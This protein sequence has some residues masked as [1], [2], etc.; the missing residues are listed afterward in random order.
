MVVYLTLQ[1]RS[2]SMP[3]HRRLTT[4]LPLV[5]VSVASA[6]DISS[7]QFHGFAS[8]GYLRT[9]GDLYEDGGQFGRDTNRGSFEFNEFGLNAI[10]TPAD[11]LRIGI[12]L[13]AYDLGKYGNDQ[14]QLDWAF[15]EYQV[16]VAWDDLSLS[17]V[18]GRFKTGHAFY[19]DYRD[20]DMTRTAVFLPRSTYSATF[21]DFFLAANGAQI[22]GSLGLHAAGSLD[23]SAFTGTQNLNESQGP[24]RDIFASAVNQDVALPGLGNLSLRLDKFD[25]LV[26]QRMNGGNLTWNTPVDGLRFKGSSLYAD[27]FKARGS[28]TATLPQ[29]AFLG[30]ASGTSTK[31]DVEIDVRHWFDIT[32]GAEYQVGDLTLAS[33]V[34]WQYYYASSQIGAL[35]F[36]PFGTADPYDSGPNAVDIANRT[37]GG[38]LSATYQLAFLPGAWSHLSVYGAGTLERNTNPLQDSNS[39]TRSGALAL[40]YDVADHFLVKGQFDRVQETDTTG[41]ATYGSQFSLK[42]TFDF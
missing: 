19:N 6:A 20:L 7:V 21:R 9:A 27:S 15:G 10:A 26:L 4:L 14:V 8:Q 35:D 17:V 11:R 41:D 40:R 38:Y 33:E 42:T 22:N 32:T 3:L 12:Q 24:M 2:L 25:S 18:A 23:F 39:Y 36:A 30:G 13:N 29:S 5:A 31:T 37:T 34:T 1:P 28:L 16:P